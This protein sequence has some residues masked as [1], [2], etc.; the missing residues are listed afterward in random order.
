MLARATG[1]STTVIA[2]G[3]ASEALPGVILT[4]APRTVAALKT[5]EAMKRVEMEIIVE[6]TKI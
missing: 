4:G 1:V 5:R 3:T 6:L 2:L